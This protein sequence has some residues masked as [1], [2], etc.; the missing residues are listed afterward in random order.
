[1]GSREVLIVED[2]ILVAMALADVLETAGLPATIATSGKEAL[3]LLD[4][5]PFSLAYFDFQLPDLT[6]LELYRQIRS[7]RPELVPHVMTG[8]SLEHLLTFVAPHQKISVIEKQ[9]GPEELTEV[10]QSCEENQIV[11]VSGATE[12]FASEL[13]RHLRMSGAR[14]WIFEGRVSGDIGETPA[15]EVPDTVIVD[16]VPLLEAM[17]RCADIREMGVKAPI[18]VVLS[19]STDASGGRPLLSGSADF[20]CYFKPVDPEQVLRDAGKHFAV[21][22]AA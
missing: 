21:G 12:E 1:M 11:V 14:A 6:A 7:I 10:V 20:R 19:H 8:F 13:Q 4:D 17:S 5:R 3:A 9:L 18:V 15:A 2:S 22:G 16:S